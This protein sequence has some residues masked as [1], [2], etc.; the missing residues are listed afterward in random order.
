VV[1]ALALAAVPAAAQKGRSNK[2]GA[3]RSDVRADHVQSLN[4]SQDK[5]RD[6]SPDNDKNKGRHEGE[7][8]GKH[9]AR[10]HRH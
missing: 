5:D 9:R 6:R 2:G 10:G 8:K 3:Q 7:R 1:I 4:K